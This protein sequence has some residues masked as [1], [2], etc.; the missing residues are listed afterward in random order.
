MKDTEEQLEK[1]KKDKEELLKEY[2]EIEKLKS[3]INKFNRRYINGIALAVG[4]A[5]LTIATI[6]QFGI[7]GLYVLGVCII[8]ITLILW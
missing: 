5:F 7:L 1:F 2:Y 3:K 4:S 6:A 8:F